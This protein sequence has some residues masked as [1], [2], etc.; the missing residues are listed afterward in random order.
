[1]SEPIRD[2]ASVT[3]Q[4]NPRKPQGEAGAEML[5]RMNRSHAEVTAWGISFLELKP[6]DL[7][8]DIGCGG[9]AALAYMAKTVTK[10]HLT[11]ID[12]SPVS[13]QSASAYNRDLIAENRMEIMEGSVEALP[14]PDSSFDRIITVESFYF[15]PSPQENLREVRRIL[16]KGGKFLLIADIYGRDDLPQT[17]L[18][19][20]EKYGLYNPDPDTFLQLFRSAGFAEPRIHLKDETTWICVEGNA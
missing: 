17:A 4:G 16:K 18:D 10:G 1:M 14:F 12:Y 11:G 15:W 7:V 9:G 6:D 20:I 3:V 2:E 19:N 5:S 13:V 8:L